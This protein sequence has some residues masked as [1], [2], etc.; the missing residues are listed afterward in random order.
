MSLFSLFNN[1]DKPGPGVSK[2]EP[3][4]SAPIRF[5]EILWRKLSKLI[6]VNLIYM[7]PMVFVIA[8]MVG[9]YLLPVSHFAFNSKIF[10]TLDLFNL[11]VVP[12]PTMLLGPFNCGMAYITRNFAREE[13]AFVWSDFWDAVKENWKSGLL[14][15]I[16]AYIEYVV[17][18]FGFVFYFDRFRTAGVGYIIPLI[19]VGLL[20]AI[21]LFSQFY[22]PVIIVTIDLKLR[23][24]YR[25][26]AIFAI[27]GVVRNI[28][29]TCALLAMAVG[30]WFCPGQFLIVPFALF[31]L[32]A[33][34]FVSYLCS[35]STYSLIDMF[36]IQPFYKREAEA[37]V[38]AKEEGEE[39][40]FELDELDDDEE[41][42][43]PQ[44]VYVNGRLIEKSRLNEDELF[45][46]NNTS[47]EK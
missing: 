13:H 42:D 3:K 11:Y 43:G 28:L 15:T 36:L 19:L 1:Y 45:E 35:F 17:L 12:L 5:F 37:N 7:I 8:M 47:E 9:L 26:G 4:K 10:G 33:C 16:I 40:N 25:N 27:M 24:I 23:H 29:I 32:F 39:F 22:I 41:D 31:A 14:N 21:A 46:T 18:S 30:V 20:G 34:S 38:P 6:Q 2:D 44:Y